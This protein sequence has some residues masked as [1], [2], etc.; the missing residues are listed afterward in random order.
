MCD[1][2]PLA[3]VRADSGNHDVMK[4]HHL[5]RCKAAKSETVCRI[6]FAYRE[7]WQLDL[8]KAVIFHRPE[9]IAPGGIQCLDCP[10]AFGAPYP[11]CITRR[12]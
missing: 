1:P 3:C 8:V 10:V 2:L 9:H 6:C 5:I 4:A 7:E 11:E 12:R